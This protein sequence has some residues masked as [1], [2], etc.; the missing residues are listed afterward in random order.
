M[1]NTVAYFKIQSRSILQIIAMICNLNLYNVASFDSQPLV[2]DDVTSSRDFRSLE[3]LCY[4][5]KYMF[6]YYIINLNTYVCT[7][8]L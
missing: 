4:T 2:T 3:I 7:L 6:M 8:I 5:F 1:K